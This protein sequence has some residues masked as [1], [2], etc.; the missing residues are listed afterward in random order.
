VRAPKH[1]K[2][3]LS[4]LEPL[5]TESIRGMLGQDFGADRAAWRFIERIE[6]TGRPS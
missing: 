3:T 4:I 5:L 6:D 2:V 1:K